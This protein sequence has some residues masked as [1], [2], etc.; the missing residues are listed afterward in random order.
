MAVGS[1]P[2]ASSAKSIRRMWGGTVFQRQKNVSRW[3]WSSR[4]RSSG[5]G[6]SGGS[7]VVPCGRAVCDAGAVGDSA[8]TEAL[9]ATSWRVRA[10]KGTQR[11]DD[12]AVP[13][14]S[15]GSS[16]WYPAK[17]IDCQ[18]EETKRSKGSESWTGNKSTTG[19]PSR[20]TKITAISCGESARDT[21]WQS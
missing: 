19:D 10:F 21:P 1:Q 3:L 9:A 17:G 20:R 16:S 15:P 13:R 4:W 11:S 5:G 18:P 7:G 6:S 12:D 14:T 2:A 8:R